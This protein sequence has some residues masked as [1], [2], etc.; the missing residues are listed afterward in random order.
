[1]IRVPSP[2]VKSMTRNP[3]V[4]ASRSP[5]ANPYPEIGRR[6]VPVIGSLPDWG[7]SGVNIYLTNL[8]RELKRGSIDTTLLLSNPQDDSTGWESS[9]PGKVVRCPPTRP[10]QVRH[11][12]EGVRQFLLRQAPCVYFPN[13]DFDVHGICPI[14]PEKVITL[15]VIHSDEEA[16]YQ[17]FCRYGA[18]WNHTVAVS[19]TIAEELRRRV[20]ALAD[21]VSVIGCGVEVPEKAPI[22]AGGPLRVAYCGRLIQYAKRV[23]RLAA[24]ILECHRR[25]LSVEFLIAGTGPDEP[26]FRKM[27]EE[28]LRAGRVQMLGRLANAEVL[29]HLEE[30]QVMILTSDFEGF[31]VVL[32]EAMSRGCVPVVSNVDSGVQDLVVPGTNGFLIEREKVTD[33]VS[34]LAELAQDR[35]LCQRLGSAAHATLRRGCHSVEWMGQEYKA[36]FERC[37]QEVQ[38]GAYRR[39]QGRRVIPAEYGIVNRFKAWIRLRTRVRSCLAR[40]QGN[41][42]I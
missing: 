6:S 9:F 5:A 39:P 27:V 10:A 11:R 2:K 3:P 38:S 22:K 18:Y 26:G 29:R 35:N 15:G 17:L 33:Y 40:L 25:N 21:R 30:S 12:Q 23:D 13:Y 14:L 1:L 24:V 4:V 36:I 20:P 16:Y 19:R 32:L 28:P 34:V 31:S 42:A 37:Q 41:H 8:F 7:V